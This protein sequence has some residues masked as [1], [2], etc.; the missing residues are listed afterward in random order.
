MAQKES[1][2]PQI[3]DFF[4]DIGPEADIGRHFMLL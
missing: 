3:D 2:A 1:R 4:N